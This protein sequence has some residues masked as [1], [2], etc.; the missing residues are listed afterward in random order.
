MEGKLEPARRQLQR[1]S[2]RSPANAECR[3][4]LAEVASFARN[5]DDPALGRFRRFLAAA[6]LDA[7]VALSARQ[8][9]KEADFQLRKAIE[10]FPAF[11]PAHNELGTRLVKE[12]RFDEARVEFERAL[13]IDPGSASAHNN[14]G[15]VFF[16]KGQR[17]AAVEQ[18]REALRLQ[19]EFPLARENLEQAVRKTG[20]K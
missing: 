16:L 18:Y 17:A 5:P 3:Q 9:K 14:L 13:E 7:S 12:G 11:A 2:I 20:G 4:L 19:P 1:E 10:L 8:K 6:H 15:F